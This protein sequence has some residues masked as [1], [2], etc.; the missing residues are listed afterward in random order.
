VRV[1]QTKATIYKTPSRGY[2]AYTVVWFEGATRKRKVFSSFEEA[3]LHA[4]SMVNSLSKGEADRGGRIR[5][6]GMPVFEG[7]IIKDQP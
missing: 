7:P 4:S 2:V 1:G 6:T 5:K 3:E